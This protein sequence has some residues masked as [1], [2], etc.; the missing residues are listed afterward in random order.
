MRTSTT[1]IKWDIIPD[2][3]TTILVGWGGAN[4]LFRAILY[5]KSMFIGHAAEGGLGPR[6]LALRRPGQKYRAG[7]LIYRH[8]AE[9]TM[10][11][12]VLDWPHDDIVDY[13]RRLIDKHQPPWNVPNGHYRD[14]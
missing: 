7:R 4:G 12:A 8:R 5:G 14:F 1:P 9:I 10:R 13:L 2:W 6:L 11:V 3:H